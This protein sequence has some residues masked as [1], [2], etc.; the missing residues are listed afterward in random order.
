[1][2]NQEVFAWFEAGL[3]REG[4]VRINLWTAERDSKRH[5]GGQRREVAYRS[6]LQF[7]SPLSHNVQTVEGL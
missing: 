3:N 6:W 2:Q 7:F 1:M 5:P 4:A